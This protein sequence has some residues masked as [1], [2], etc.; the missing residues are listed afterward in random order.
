MNPITKVEMNLARAVVKAVEL[1]EGSY[2][3]DAADLAEGEFTDYGIFYTRELQ[4]CCEEA[5]VEFDIGA[6]AGRLL[7]LALDAWQNDT[8]QWAKQ[9]LDPSA[10]CSPTSM[11]CQHGNAYP[12][13]TDVTEAD[14]PEEE[15]PACF[16]CANYW[17][18]INDE[19]S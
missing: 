6:G 10:I 2:D 8:W 19:V 17:E 9:I 14:E 5:C 3:H 16:A 18:N 4:S 7:F 13:V 11:H 1:R 15:T 12:E